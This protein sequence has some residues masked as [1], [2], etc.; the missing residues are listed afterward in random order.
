MNPSCR[1]LWGSKRDSNALASRWKAMAA[2][3]ADNM[4]FAARGRWSLAAPV[5]TLRERIDRRADSHSTVEG[6]D[7]IE[8]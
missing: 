8:R 5:E 6:Y 7:E 4:T 3:L 1:A 2:R